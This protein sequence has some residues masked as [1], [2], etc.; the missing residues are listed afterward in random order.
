MKVPLF[1]N[2]QR[3]GIYYGRTINVLPRYVPF[4]RRDVAWLDQGIDGE[5]SGHEVRKSRQNGV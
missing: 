3:H 5:D 1:V 2:V 4:C